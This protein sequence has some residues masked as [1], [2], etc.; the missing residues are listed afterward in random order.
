ML[1][2]GNV[3]GG[4]RDDDDDGGGGDINDQREGHN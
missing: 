3:V 2:N 1:G 4:K